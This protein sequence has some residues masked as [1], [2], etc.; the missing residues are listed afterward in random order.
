MLSDLVNGI[1]NFFTFTA[2]ASALLGLIAGII[3]GALPGLTATMSVAIL[4]PFTFFMETALALPFLLGIY[5]GAIYGGSI[6]AILINTPG[7]NAAAATTL[8][9]YPLAK[10]GHSRKAL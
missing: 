10:Q 5:K 6:P 3:I 9:G 2:I 4:T 8:D 7:T 1:A